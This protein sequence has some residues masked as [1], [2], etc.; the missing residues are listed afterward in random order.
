MSYLLLTEPI[1][2]P[3]LRHVPDHGAAE[4]RE[5][6]AVLEDGGQLVGGDVAGAGG[7]RAARGADQ[8]LDVGVG[9]AGLGPV[10]PR[11]QVEA[12][13][14]VGLLALDE[15]RHAAVV[16]VEL[17][18]EEV[19]GHVAVDHVR[20]GRVRVR[21]LRRRRQ[22]VRP[23]G[24]AVD[25]GLEAPRERQQVRRRRLEVEV[26]PVHHRRPERPVLVA[27]VRPEEAPHRVR[28][29][30]GRGFVGESAFR[31]RHPAQGDQ[32]RLA[33]VGLAG[34]DVLPILVLGLASW[35]AD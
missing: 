17:D 33:V 3:D 10:V 6:L 18:H 22:V 11:G 1:V 27:R 19:Q 26:E 5:L 4:A 14:R 25:V 16:V 21:A 15:R 34:F 29:C 32:D 30:L 35:L 8:D 9:A 28:A 2:R 13:V 20:H 12:V 24:V 31:V 7:A 23:G